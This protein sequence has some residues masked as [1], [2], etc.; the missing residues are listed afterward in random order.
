MLFSGGI[1]WYILGVILTIILLRVKGVSIV[2]LILAFLF[3]I[4][5]LCGISFIYPDLLAPVFESIMPVSDASFYN[6]ALVASRSAIADGG[7]SG[8]GLGKGSCRLPLPWYRI[9]WEVC[10]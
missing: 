2:A 1:G 6:Q 9:L 3:S 7:I 10:G 5:V 4:A 8:A